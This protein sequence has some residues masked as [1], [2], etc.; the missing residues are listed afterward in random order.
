MLKMLSKA[1]SIKELLDN[2]YKFELSELG[3]LSNYTF[4]ELARQL[5]NF[6]INIDRFEHFFVANF[7]SRT[8][9]IRIKYNAIGK[10]VG[11]VNQDWR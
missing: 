9:L 5:P 2:R 7:E 3:D 10:F 11:I 6:Q 8:T 1:F 4:T